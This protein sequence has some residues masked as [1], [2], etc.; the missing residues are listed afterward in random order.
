MI[1]DTA[2]GEWRLHPALAADCHH[3]G[4]LPSSRL[5]L[6]R[7]A[8]LHWFILVPET[9][10][11]DL[12]DLPRD[13]L[14]ALLEDARR[15]AGFLRRGLGYQRVNV[16]ALGLRVAQLHLHVI[17]RREDDPCWPNP[18]WGALQPGPDY[19]AEELARLAG[20]LLPPPGT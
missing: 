16:G 6:Q 11:R 9:G 8:T 18:V 10:E 1:S 5:L 3:L 7:N 20:A 12:L 15:V 17:G 4:R 13:Q 2:Q 19:T 14:A